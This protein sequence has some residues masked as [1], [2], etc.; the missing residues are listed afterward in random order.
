MRV[1]VGEVLVVARH[2]EQ[3]RVGLVDG[4]DRLVGELLTSKMHLV[5]VLG[6]GVALDLGH[7]GRVDL[8]GDHRVPVELQEPGVLAQLLRSLL[9]KKGYACRCACAGPSRRAAA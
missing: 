6:V 7:E 1:V 3:Q 9:S 8:L 2:V 5:E 4:V